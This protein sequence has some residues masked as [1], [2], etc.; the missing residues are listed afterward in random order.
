MESSMKAA[1]LSPSNTYN[2]TEIH[3]PASLIWL[4]YKRPF[5]T[6]FMPHGTNLNQGTTFPGE[7]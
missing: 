4:E 7:T 3:P 1:L 2:V 6:G 5:L